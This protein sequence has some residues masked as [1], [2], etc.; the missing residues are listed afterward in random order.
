MDR[1]VATLVLE[2]L[3]PAS[4]E[5]SLETAKTLERERDQL[6]KLSEQ[7]MERAAYEV[8]RAAR[9][10]RLVEPENRLVAR[11]LER[12]WEEKLA[13][14]RKVREDIESLRR[15]QPRV[16]TE[17]ER[18]AIRSL[19]A[20]IPALW[21]AP[22]TTHAER[23]EILRQVLDRVIVDTQGESERVRIAIEWA[24][25][26][27]TQNEMARPVRRLEQLSYFPRMGERLRQLLVEGLTTEEIAQRFNAEGLR[28]PKASDR[29]Q[30]EGIRKL[31]RR[32]G[33]SE[34]PSRSRSTDHA[35]LNQDEWW[36]AEVAARIPMPEMTL[37]TWIQRGWVKARQLDR[38][39]RRW[40]VWAD[41]N[42]VERLRALHKEP[43]GQRFHRQWTARKPG[44]IS[45]L[46]DVRSN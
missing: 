12:E 30:K 6:A 5:L 36:L 46:P 40:A 35:G 9:Q 21:G 25:G 43:V 23:K 8:D 45:G 15:S 34:D 39:R 14:Q 38:P 26:S 24:G 4:L 27:R 41:E 3:A 31:M 19:A 33:L 32:L 17:V 1:F 20:D 18:E 42:E 29:Y 7:R 10:F 2:A 22:T 37:L 11:Q 16:L 28:P 13:A 44:G